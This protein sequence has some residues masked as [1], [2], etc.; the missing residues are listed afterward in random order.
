M[1]REW[2]C[3]STT[4]RLFVLLSSGNGDEEHIPIVLYLSRKK[5]DNSPWSFGNKQNQKV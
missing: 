4:I 1:D 5:M 2:I 3:R